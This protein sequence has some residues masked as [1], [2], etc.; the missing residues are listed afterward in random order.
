MTKTYAFDVYGTLIDT[1][2]VATQL[3]AWRPG[4]GQAMSVTWRNKQLEYAFRRGLMNEYVPFSTCTEQ[5][6]DYTCAAHQT[7]LAPEQKA[8]LL[9]LY[10]RLPCFD[11]VKESLAS[12]VAKGHRLIAFSNG[13]QHSVETLLRRAGIRDEFAQIISCEEVK[14]FKPNPSVY[15][16]LLSV[17]Q[18]NDTYLVSSNPFDVLGAQSA[19]IKTVWL[20]R[21]VDV[22][23]DPW[24][25]EPD[26]VIRRLT[27]L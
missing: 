23:F 19:G 8:Q 16:H 3:E 2:F 22:P 17:T 18:D 10:L 15:Q 27:E 13:E 6:L 1:H 7:T 26:R 9:D 21:S 25:V 5:A 24:G 4:L 14:T 20:Q 12:L 11:D